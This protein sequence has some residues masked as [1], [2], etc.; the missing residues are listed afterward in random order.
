MFFISLSR[1]QCI[2]HDINKLDYS[3]SDSSLVNQIIN[4]KLITASGGF[5]LSQITHGYA[6]TL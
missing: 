3:C 6:F 4:N 5:T 2:L 1:I